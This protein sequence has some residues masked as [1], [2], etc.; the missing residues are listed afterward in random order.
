MEDKYQ[1]FIDYTKGTVYY[2]SDTINKKELFDM[3]KKYILNYFNEDV[4]DNR[5]GVFFK[6][7]SKLNFIAIKR[8]EPICEFVK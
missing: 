2:N 8:N 3:F 5:I 4:K 7:M 1:S 6:R